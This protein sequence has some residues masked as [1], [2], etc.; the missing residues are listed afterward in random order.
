MD[1]SWILIL[2]T[3]CRDEGEHDEGALPEND[4]AATSKPS[5]SATVAMQHIR[6]TTIE[7]WRNHS[8][9]ALIQCDIALF[10]E[11][12]TLSREDFLTL[13]WQSPRQILYPCGRENLLLFPPMKHSKYSLSI[14]KCQMEPTRTFSE[15]LL[16]PVSIS[17]DTRIVWRTSD[18]AHAESLIA[19]TQVTMDLVEA[20]RQFYRHVEASALIE[21]YAADWT[22][23]ASVTGNVNDGNTIGDTPDSQ[24]SLLLLKSLK[25]KIESD[26]RAIDNILVFM[27]FTGVLLVLCLIK[28]IFFDSPPPSSSS[29]RKTRPTEVRFA[30]TPKERPPPKSPWLAPPPGVGLGTLLFQTPQ[31]P[32]WNVPDSVPT[33]GTAAAA[34]PPTA[35]SF[36]APPVTASSTP[37]TT[38]TTRTSTASLNHKES[39]MDVSPCQKLASE[40]AR[41]KEER[42]RNRQPMDP[43]RLV[44]PSEPSS[45]VEEDD[46]PAAMPTIPCTP[47]L[48]SET[49]KGKAA[50]IKPI[51]SNQGSENGNGNDVSGFTSVAKQDDPQKLARNL[52]S[53]GL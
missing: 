26:V 4:I 38:T 6:P 53:F 22:G 15:P 39:E 31:S 45:S 27:A 36:M 37:A 33:T 21:K 48:V 9:E 41:R 43:R 50:I 30:A 40:W 16:V 52:W 8:S 46:K 13:V 29:S 24:T 20:S 42:R 32:R 3:L 19:H 11:D 18:A 35:P 12:L 17:S 49:K 2:E 5:Y 25:A 10:P 23:F 51:N 14:S 34:A 28:L 1:S 7:A 47:Q 44:P